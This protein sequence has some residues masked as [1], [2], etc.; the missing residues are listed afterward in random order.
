[1]G[2]RAKSVNTLCKKIPF[3]LNIEK[4]ISNKMAQTRVF[5]LIPFPKYWRFRANFGSKDY[6]FKSLRLTYG[7]S[8]CLFKK[9]SFMIFYGHFL[10][11]E[12][13]GV[14][15]EILISMVRAQFWVK[16]L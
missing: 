10:E 2:L 5:Y 7:L 13:F 11:I 8:Y 14:F 4:N 16:R 15:A 1:M 12:I 6:D 9:F 3:T